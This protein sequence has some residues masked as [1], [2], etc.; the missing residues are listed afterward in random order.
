MYTSTKKTGSAFMRKKTLQSVLSILPVVIVILA[1]RAYPIF[2]AFV[3][4]FTNWNGMFKNDWVGLDNY[5]SIIVDGPFWTLLRNNFVLLLNVPL[6]IIAGLVV[7]VLLYEEVA[8]WRFFRSLYYVPQI[9][10]AVIIGY[11][12]RI[13]FGYEGPFNLVLKNIGLE[14]LAIEWF[15]NASTALPVVI[16]CLV[17]FSIGWQA[18]LILGGMSSIPTSVFEAAI[19]DGANYWQRTF[20]IV[21]PMLVRVIEYS[22]IMC[23]VWT[24]TQLFPFI[25]SMTKGGPGYETSTLDYMIYSKAFVGGNKLGEACA[26]SVILLIIILIIT[27]VEMKFANKADDWGE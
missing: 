1:V 21:L 27:V 23:G 7:A 14:N 5:I 9:I 26:I 12:F 4:S 3:K 8:G 20:K 11:L 24:F 16:V 17:W 19:I 15:G 13:F 18:I 10:S 6:Q 2:T 22:V 25:Y